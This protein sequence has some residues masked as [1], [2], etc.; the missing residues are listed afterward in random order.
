MIEP[1]LI[2]AKLDAAALGQALAAGWHTAQRSRRVSLVYASV[3]AVV[4]YAI[5][6]SL[7]AAG[8]APLMPLAAG[9]FMLLGPTL[10]AGFF[11]IAVAV[12]A[13]RDG[14]FADLLAGFRRAPPQ[15]LVVSLV[16]ALLCVIFATD[17]GILYSYQI[18]GAAI[19]FHALLQP[20]GGVAKV[21]F[22]G[23]VFGIFIGFIA[24]AIS[25]FSLPLLCERRA[26]LIRAVSASVRA[27]LLN[28][29]YAL[30]WAA[31]LS[32]VIV[33]SILVLPLLP[34]TLPPLAYASHALYRRVFPLPA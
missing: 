30:A 10:L 15:V 1:P 9:A 27:V 12:E 29:P 6:R 32:G 11:G 24:F 7:L 21:L 4:G 17:V 20:S 22:W 18:G 28:L 14:G 25:A 19:P 23:T 8:M 33:T 31:L 13:G 26:G 2:P 5:L 34:F 3:F 16:C